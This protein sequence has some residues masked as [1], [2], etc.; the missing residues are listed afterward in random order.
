LGDILAIVSWV[1]IAITVIFDKAIAPWIRARTEVLHPSHIKRTYR[2]MR[3]NLVKLRN[4][5]STLM[6]VIL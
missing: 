4:Y 1:Y 3:V 6:T 5:L 2:I